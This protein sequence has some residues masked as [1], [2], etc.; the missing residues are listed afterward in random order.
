MTEHTES[1]D[2]SHWLTWLNTLQ[3]HEVFKHIFIQYNSGYSGLSLLSVHILMEETTLLTK[4]LLHHLYWFF[5]KF[6]RVTQSLIFPVVFVSHC[7]IYLYCLA[8]IDLRLL[9]IS[10]MSSTFSH[11]NLY[12]N[13]SF[14]FC[15]INKR[16][17]Y[18]LGIISLAHAPVHVTD[19][20]VVNIHVD[21]F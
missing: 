9:I 15:F 21:E 20:P 5:V 13:M 6:E 3:S 7:H 17:I 19:F 16:A 2:W 14:C 11:S 8:F 18:L 10:L 1:L 12:S 4:L